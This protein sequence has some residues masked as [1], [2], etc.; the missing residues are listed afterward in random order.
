MDTIE[1]RVYSKGRRIR[2][3]GFLT[4]W[5]VVEVRESGVTLGVWQNT[6]SPHLHFMDWDELER[7]NVEFIS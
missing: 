6:V 2:Y 5:E 1:N 7:E 4:V 3:G